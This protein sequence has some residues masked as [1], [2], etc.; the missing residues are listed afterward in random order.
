[1]DYLPRFERLRAKCSPS[2]NGWISTPSCPPRSR[3]LRDAGWDVVVTSAG[4][5]W[6]I[7]RL[8]K[9]AGVEIEVYSNPGRFVAGQG[10]LMEM[11]RDSRF[12]SP[13]LGVNK[14]GVV[15]HY[16]TQGKTVAFAGDS[17][18]DVEPARLVNGELRFARSDLADVLRD[19]GLAYHSFDRWSEIAA[20]LVQRGV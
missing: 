15:R 11:P 13:T 10:L 19:E 16:L 1:M 3:S 7:D 14:A 20:N 5:G 6:Y 8:L 4:C 2:S 17:H 9:A 12:R 18:P